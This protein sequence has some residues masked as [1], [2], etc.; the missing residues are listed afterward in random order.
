[1]SSPAACL[2]PDISDDSTHR[3]LLL[4]QHPRARRSSV[5]R[6]SASARVGASAMTRTIGSVP[7]GRTCTHRS[8]PRQPSPSCVVRRPRPGNAAAAPSYTARSA[9][10][11]GPLVL[12]DLVPRSCRL[13]AATAATPDPTAIAASAPRRA[14]ASRP[15][16]SSGRITPPLPS[17]PITAPSS[18]MARATLASPTGD[19]TNLAPKSPPHP[20]RPGWWTDSSQRT[21]RR[22]PRGRLSTVLTANARV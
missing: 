18:L 7:D 21:P 22:L 4:N 5:T 15:R 14:G 16:W 2:W 17:P 19:R 1:M 20:R 9:A 10:P 3:S 8:R 11:P 12:H 13:R 6:A